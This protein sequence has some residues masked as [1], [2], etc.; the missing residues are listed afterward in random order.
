MERENGD[1]VEKW[2]SLLL[3][4]LELLSPSPLSTFFFN[5]GGGGRFSRSKVKGVRRRKGKKRL[6][7]SS[8]SLR[9]P[10]CSLSKQNREAEVGTGGG[11]FQGEFGEE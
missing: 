7:S 6:S 1:K 9:L 5:S 11:P 2:F 10:K 4:R 3:L 8:S